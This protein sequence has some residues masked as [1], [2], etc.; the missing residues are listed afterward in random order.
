MTYC[1]RRGR[2]RQQADGSCT[3]SAFYPMV[4]GLAGDGSERPY[5]CGRPVSAKARAG[6]FALCRCPDPDYERLHRPRQ[7]AS[8]TGAVAEAQRALT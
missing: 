8:A 7:R 3:A 6:A 5:A 4:F 2:Q 1:K